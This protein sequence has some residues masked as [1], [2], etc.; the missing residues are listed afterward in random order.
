MAGV[1]VEAD[2]DGL[3]GGEEQA[4]IFPEDDMTQGRHIFPNIVLFL[5]N[6]LYILLQCSFWP[7]SRLD[8][9]NE[10]LPL[11]TSDLNLEWRQFQ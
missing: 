11:K 4:S 9:Q 8:F 5:G 1:D 2:M 3:F 10:Y 6:I 7:I